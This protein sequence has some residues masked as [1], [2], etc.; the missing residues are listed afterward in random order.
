LELEESRERE[1]ELRNVLDKDPDDGR[2][3][4]AALQLSINEAN[5]SSKN[6]VAN[7]LAH[8]VVQKQGNGN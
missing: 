6:Y 2:M 8:C 5:K 1:I 3:A 4:V 7:L